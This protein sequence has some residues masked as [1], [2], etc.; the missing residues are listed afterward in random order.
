MDATATASPFIAGTKIQYAWDS[1]SLNW[2][3][4]CPRKYQYCMIEGYQSK[5]KS[6]DLD[7]GS[8][9]HSGIEL[10]EHVRQNGHD[11]NTALCEVVHQALINTRTWTSDDPNKNRETL[12]RSLI[13]YLDEFVEDNA[14]TITLANGKPAVEL[15]F[16]FKLDF[17]VETLGEWTDHGPDNYRTRTPQT[18]NYMLCGHIDRLVEFAGANYV[19][20][21]KTTKNTLSAAYFAG[22][23]PNNQMTLY[24]IAAKIVFATLA[25]GVIID[26]AQIAVGFTRFERGVTLR[27]QGQVEEWLNDLHSLLKRNEEYAA[28]NYWPMNDTACRICQFK[29]ICSKD[30]S[31]RQMFLDADFERRQWNPLTPR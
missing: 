12:L 31:V 2:L 13:W 20:D 19:M 24:T 15:S 7:F 6:I 23:E 1:T 26:A 27:T 28:A 22:F 9:Y 17:G 30:P 3:K 25:K 16:K 14:K 29:K 8:E 11:H 4:E 5:M 21:H 18:I 10:Y